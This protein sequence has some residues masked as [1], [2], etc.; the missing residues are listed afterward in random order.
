VPDHS[1]NRFGSFRASGVLRHVFER[2]V[3]ARIA[4]E[5]VGGEG[6]AVVASLIEVDTTKTIRCRMLL[7][8]SNASHPAH[9]PI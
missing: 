3:L 9:L 7:D 5:L 6:F 1:K 8:Q 2:I 4:A